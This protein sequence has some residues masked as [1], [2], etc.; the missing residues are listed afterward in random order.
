MEECRHNEHHYR[1]RHLSISGFHHGCIEMSPGP[2]MYR[3][4]PRAPETSNTLRV[5]EKR[6]IVSIR[7]IAVVQKS[8]SN[9]KSCLKI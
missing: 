8:I 4:I 7:M 2:F 5:P 3:N 9:T 6:I 1:A